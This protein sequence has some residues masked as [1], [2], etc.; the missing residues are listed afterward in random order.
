MTCSAT[1]TTLLWTQEAQKRGQLRLRR[2]CVELE[3]KTH[4]P[5]TSATVILRSLAACKSTW[6]LCRE[7]GVRQSRLEEGGPCARRKGRT[8]TPAVMASLRFLAV[9]MSSRVR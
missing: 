2:K 6:S 8:P 3:K 5:V 9:A 4:L 7:V 1:E